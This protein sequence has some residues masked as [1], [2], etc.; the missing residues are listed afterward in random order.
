MSTSVDQERQLLLR[1][2]DKSPLKKAK[3]S[4][5]QRYLPALRDRRCLDIGAD[6][7][8]IS[9]LLRDQGGEWSSADLDDDVVESI[10]MMVGD[11][12]YR[13][14]GGRT[15]FADD[16]FDVVVIID[17]LEHIRDDK[18]FVRE[19]S[20]VLK[21]DG[22]LIVNVPHYKPRSSIRKL[23]L[24]AGLTDEKHGHVR[25]GYTIPGLAEVLAPE[26][27]VQDKHT[28]SRFFVEL[29][30]V[31]VS[32]YF[33]RAKQG[34]SSSKGNVVTGDDLQKR[35]KQFKLFSIIYPVVA[36]LQALDRLLFFTAG[37]SLIVKAKPAGTRP[38]N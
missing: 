6:N 36:S 14:D 4:A 28:Y 19:L 31:A 21:A 1:L 38:G 24:M 37:Y 18:G 20:R 12:V 3:Y 27:Q 30:D 17:F 10:R 8:V 29:F 9:Y 7:G 2:F 25:P 32:L 34:H 5:I 15:P 26:F 16:T 11:E 35:S 13:L 22:T 23:R 33:D